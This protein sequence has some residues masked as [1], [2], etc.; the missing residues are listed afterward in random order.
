MPVRVYLKPRAGL[1]GAAT[2][3]ST[4]GNPAYRNYQT[5]ARVEQQF[6]TTAAESTAV[7]DWPTGQGITVTAANAT[8]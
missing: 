8:T 1:V 5:P 3:V 2:A 4:P 6:G 7:R